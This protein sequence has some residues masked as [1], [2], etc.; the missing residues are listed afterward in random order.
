M[1]NEGERWMLGRRGQTNGSRHST[2]AK[3]NC[4]HARAHCVKNE[5]PFA[6]KFL[7]IGVTAT[8]TAILVTSAVG[9]MGFFL[10]E[11]GVITITLENAGQGTASTAPAIEPRP[12]AKEP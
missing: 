1:R 6:P 9:A 11:S 10:T 12:A 8:I 7:A 2:H 4:T 3:R 5:R